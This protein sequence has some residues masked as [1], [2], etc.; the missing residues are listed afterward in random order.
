MKRKKRKETTRSQDEDARRGA[1]VEGSPYPPASDGI[2]IFPDVYE[3]TA[4]PV[5]DMPGLKPLTAEE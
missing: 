1:G 4:R 3:H 2:E 5:T